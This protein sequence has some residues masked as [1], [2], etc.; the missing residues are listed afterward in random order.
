MVVGRSIFCNTEVLVLVAKSSISY[1]IM[2]IYIYI[3]LNIVTNK[4]Q[5]YKEMILVVYMIGTMKYCAHEFWKKKIP[6][7]SHL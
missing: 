6:R 4:N 1:E 3:Y 5:L 2:S 7:N